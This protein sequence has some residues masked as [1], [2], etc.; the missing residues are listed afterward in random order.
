MPLIALLILVVPIVELVLIVEVATRIGVF[1]T[2]FLLIAISVAG[3]WLLKR[4]GAA[5]WRRLQA[6]MQRGE[7]PANEVIDGVMIVFGGALLLTPGFLTDVVGLAL[8]LPPTR[9]LLRRWGRRVTQVVVLR[10][11][12]VAGAAVSG[13]KRIYDARVTRDRRLEPPDAD[14]SPDKA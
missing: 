1:E 12:G 7:V 10:R 11:F 4:E 13:G 6:T 5:A 2:L 8:L 3:A 9:A 14:D